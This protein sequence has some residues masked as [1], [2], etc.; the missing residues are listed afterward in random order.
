MK[1]TLNVLLLLLA[2][3]ISAQNSD[4]K[5]PN[6]NAANSLLKEKI[7]KHAPDLDK[8]YQLSS[9][10]HGKT[11]KDIEIDLDKLENQSS[12]TIEKL[13]NL[14]HNIKEQIL[15]TDNEKNTDFNSSIKSLKDKIE[16]DLVKFKDDKSQTLEKLNNLDSIINKLYITEYT[17]STS[18][19]IKN[20]NN[21]IDILK[22]EYKKLKSINNEIIK[23]K[24]L[25]EE[26]KKFNALKLQYNNTKKEFESLIKNIP[27]GEYSFTY[28]D[29]KYFAFIADPLV[30]NVIITDSS[31]QKQNGISV[32]RLIDLEK[33]NINDIEMITNGGMFENTML[34]VGLMVINKKIKKVINLG[35]ERPNSNFFMLP[36]GV[37]YI[38]NDSLFVTNTPNYILKK[39][40]PDFATQSGPMLVDNGNRHNEFKYKSQNVYNRSGV[41]IL[42]N[43]RA[44]F[45]IS[46][47]QNTNFFDFSSIFMDI[48]SCKNAL[49]LD[50]A[51]SEMYLKEHENSIKGGGGFGSLI[52]VKRKIKTK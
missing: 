5:K 24:N 17:D 3:Q 23:N 36:N 19:L 30:H 32:N 10:L 4:S 37:F 40:H 34:P 27:E 26:V 49:Y 11:K 18:I 29:N 48:F 51:I 14:N 41:G 13:K 39:P 28:N 1:K 8:Y 44:I 16:A 46:E 43:N 42:P 25:I 21:D 38:Q 35:P 50:G 9:N 2:F 6:L 15:V 47:K 12:I 22:K 45:I 52:Y 33:N 31:S 7:N 20:F